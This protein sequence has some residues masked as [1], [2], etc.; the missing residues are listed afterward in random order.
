MEAVAEQ[1]VGSYLT[2]G[3]KIFIAPQYSVPGDRPNTESSCPDFVAL[4]FEKPG[5]REVLLVEVN[6]GSNFNAL[7]DRAQDRKDRWFDPIRMKMLSGGIID[8]R[9]SFR[10]YG[11]IRGELLSSLRVMKLAASDD[12]RFVAI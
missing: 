4:S 8:Q 11:F 12:V 2:R 5:N 7:C 3:G 1:L 9:W 6:S 10:F